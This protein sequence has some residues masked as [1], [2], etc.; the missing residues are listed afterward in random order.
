MAADSTGH[1]LPDYAADR[2][3]MHYSPFPVSEG[4]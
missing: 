1:F 4:K 2:H 3:F